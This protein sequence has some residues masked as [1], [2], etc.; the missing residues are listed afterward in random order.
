MIGS[1]L[2]EQ[3]KFD[4]VHVDAGDASPGEARHVVGPARIVGTF[5]GSDDL[6]PGVFTQ[7][8]DYFSIGPVFPTHTKPTSTEPI[9]VDGVHHLRRQAGA[10]VLLVAV[11]GITIE[12]AKAVLDAGAN[13]VAVAGAIFR[14]PD[15]AEEFRR[16]IKALG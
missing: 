15:P 4:G 12:T 11:G 13:T 14:T 5:G 8:A 16:W 10:K 1:I 9:G 3:L 7:P 6:L 2:L